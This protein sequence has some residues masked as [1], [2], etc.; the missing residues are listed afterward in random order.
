M[1][2]I[3]NLYQE[4]LSLQPLSATDQKRLNDK[5]MLE[6]NYNSNHIEG[7]TLTYGQTILLLIHGKVDGNAPMHDYEEMKAHHAALEF[8]KQTAIAKEKR[9]LTESFIRQVHLMMLKEDYVIYENRE[10]Q[11]IQYTIHAGKYKTR[12]NS[13]QTQTGEV[14]EYASPEETPAL[15]A[16][17]IA[18][19]NTAE[20]EGKLSPLELASIFHYRYIRIHPFEDGNGRI[21]RLMVN[22][23]LALHGYPMIV[24]HTEDKTNYLSALEKCD[25]V[26]GLLPSIGAHA[27]L[28]QI[29]PLLKYLGSCLERALKIGIKAARGEDIEEEDDLQKKLAI[30][31]RNAIKKREGIKRIEKQYVLDIFNDFMIP[32]GEK[33]KQKSSVFNQ[34][35]E[36]ISV[37]NLSTHTYGSQRWKLSKERIEQYSPEKW[38]TR[39]FII[40]LLLSKPTILIPANSVE[41]INVY[42]DFSDEEYVITLL[43]RKYSFRYDC[44]PPDL[45]QQEWLK[46]ITAHL[47]DS[48]EIKVQAADK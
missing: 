9:P 31:A 21:A 8:V 14:F 32:F 35:Y 23:I 48:I 1:T 15:M 22:Y 47:Y 19:Y 13:V 33:L 44:L 11:Q 20:T 45:Q 24:V 10:G 17:L 40:N 27:S 37:N 12:P 18:W 4:W 5:F 36:Q 38:K 3:D 6:F 29:E 42:I 26:V 30:L 43:D 7:N 39:N 25:S 41:D 16:D 46:M 2:T 34:F 28:E